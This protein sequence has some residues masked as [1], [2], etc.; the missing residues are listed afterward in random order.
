MK[1]NIHAIAGLLLV[2]LLSLSTPVFAVSGDLSISDANVWFSNDYFFEGSPTRIWA[3]VQN[4]S[5]A[6]LLG[7][8]RFTSKDGIIGSDQ[9]I[10]ALAGKTDDVFVDWTPP[11]YGDYTITITVIPWDGTSDNPANNVV[12]K[13]V[14]VQ[15]D[16]DHDGIPNSTDPDKDGDGVANEEDAFPLNSLEWKDTDGDGQGNNQDTDDDNDGTLDSED[17]MPEDSRYT[18]DQDKDGIPDEIDEDIDGDGLSNKDEEKVE[19]DPKN[20]DTD[21]DLTVDGNDPFPTD[22]TEWFDVDNDGIGDNSDPDIDGD[23]IANEEDLDPSNPSPVAEVDQD[24]LIA[25]LGEEITFDA[26][27]SKDDGSIVKYVWQF[28][29]ETVEGSQIVRSFDVTGL[30]TATL[31]VFD[32]KGQSDTTE[33]RVRVFDHWFLIEAG[34][35]SLLL[36]LLAFYIIYRY[37]RRALKSS[38]ARPSKKKK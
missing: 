28:G 21:G 33:I 22:S 11:T 36:V 26:S 35:F 5:T 16:T 19:S 25:S 7:T 2:S 8:V 9:P 18:K 3:S 14:T 13:T 32:D 17:E 1:K 15:Q 4:N 24:V 6:D 29:D 38:K 31:T 30:Q 37:N 20:P 12:Q 23:G 34:G 27:E 10:S